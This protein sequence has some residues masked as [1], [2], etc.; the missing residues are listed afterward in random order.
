MVGHRICFNGKMCKIIPK[1]SQI[2]L[3]IRST[4]MHTSLSL[5]PMSLPW[6]QMFLY[7]I[8][9]VVSVSGRGLSNAL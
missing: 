6:I 9:N 3:L 8:M 7:H 4:V 1:L 2:F 5:F